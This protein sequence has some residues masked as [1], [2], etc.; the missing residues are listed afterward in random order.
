[1]SFSCC[2]CLLCIY[3]IYGWHHETLHSIISFVSNCLFSVIIFS[4]LFNLFNSQRWQLVWVSCF[5]SFPFQS[6]LSIYAWPLWWWYN[7]Y[8]RWCW[9]RRWGQGFSFPLQSDFA[10]SPT[11][12]GRSK[13]QRQNMILKSE[14]YYQARLW[15]FLFSSSTLLNQI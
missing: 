14:H 9:C 6:D 4:F 12:E 3:L 7:D 13:A 8:Q 1:M 11:K 2:Y 10:F 15:N 5:F